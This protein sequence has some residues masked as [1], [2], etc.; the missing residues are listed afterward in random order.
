MHTKVPGVLVDSVAAITG[1]SKGSFPFTYLGCPIFYARRRKKY[2]ND[3]IQKVKAKLHSWKGKLLS[4][5]GKATLI[6]SVLQSIPTHVLSVLDP[7][8]N[9]L[10]HLHKVF[11]RFFWSNKDEGRSRHWTKWLKL[12]LPKE[13]GVGFRSLFDVSK[14]L[15]AKLWWRFRTSKSLWSNFMWNKYC[16]KEVPTVV[17][18]RKGSHV[19]KKMLKAREEVEH[20]ILWEMNRGSTNV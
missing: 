19:W 4:Y 18:F 8:D 6:S 15:F 11:A 5:G 20:E 14:A 16:K 10:E 17:Q 12:C 7:P 13:G 2:Y 9:V 3:L 1:F